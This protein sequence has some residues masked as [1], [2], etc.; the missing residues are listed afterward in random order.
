MRAPIRPSRSVCRRIVGRAIGTNSWSD[1]A[2]E[3]WHGHYSITP[4]LQRLAHDRF[5][6][7][8]SQIF[9]DAVEDA[10]DKT[11]GFGAAKS[12]CQFNRFVDG[13]DRRNVVAIEHLVNGK[14][15]DVSIDRGN[16]V[17]I[18]IFEI[19]FDLLVNLRQVR[20]HSFDQRLGKF[21]HVRFHRTKIP[22]IVDPFGSFAVL[23]IAPEVILDGRF[24]RASPFAHINYLLRNFAITF[25]I[26]TAARAASVPRLI[27]LSRQR[28]RA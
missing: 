1:G 14:T 26:S 22:K 8:P 27:S 5:P 15:E 20:N 3:Y 24:A 25:E 9:S 10:V 28:S 11:A 19:T 6:R 23:E 13:N 21:A 17:Q 16:A 18:I 12:F 7:R 2:K 4:L